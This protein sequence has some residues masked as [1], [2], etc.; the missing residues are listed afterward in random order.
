MNIAAPTERSSSAAIATARATSSTY[1][2][3]NAV[4]D[5]AS[6]GK[7]PRAARRT[8]G[9]NWESLG[10]YTAAGRTIVHGTCATDRTTASDASLLFP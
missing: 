2:S 6:S 10:P 8:S 7:I 1:T 5:S 4:D 3:V 9:R